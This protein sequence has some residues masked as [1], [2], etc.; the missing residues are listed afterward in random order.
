MRRNPA[1]RPTSARRLPAALGITLVAAALVAGTARGAAAQTNSFMNSG[2]QFDFPPP[3]ARSLGLAGAFV[4]VADDATAA[5][6]NPAGLTILAKPEVSI[7]GRRWSFVSVSP[8]RGHAFGS[9]TNVGADTTSGIVDGEDTRSRTGASF[10]SAVFP[11]DRFAVAFYR[12]EQTRF[13]ASFRSEGVFLSSPNFPTGE[14]RIDPYSA[15]MDLDIVNYGVAAAYRFPGGLAVGGGVALSDFDLDSETSV[16]YL[17]VG[18]GQIAPAARNQFTA[19]GLAYGPPD[20]GPN[21]IQSR[22]TESGSDKAMGVNLGALYR[23]GTGKVSIGGAIR[24]GPEFEYSTVAAWGPVQD[25]F[26]GPPD[27]GD[28]IDQDANISFKVPDAYSFGVAFRPNDRLLFSGQYDRVQFSQLSRDVRDVFGSLQPVLQEYEEGL[29][30]PDSD[31]VRFGAEYA[32]AVAPHVVSLRMGAA[33]ESDHRMQ[34]SPVGPA[35]FPR[36]EVL[37]RPGEDDWHLTPGFGIAFTN[38]QIDGAFDFSDR[39]QTFSLSAVLRF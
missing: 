13:R 39:T 21:N 26:P 16:F 1:Y 28:V 18:P 32:V 12:H 7:E 8:L 19:M 22:L 35:R 38:V 31:Q 15:A 6:A 5:V 4:A 9:A 37:F 29:R 20:F 30:F 11:K 3:G 27:S 33:Y 17:G 36:I 2:I 10:V 24:I 23:P 25:R 14:D 34:Y